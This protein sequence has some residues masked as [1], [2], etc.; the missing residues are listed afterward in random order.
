MSKKKVS[1]W[2]EYEKDESGK[3]RYIGSMYS[4]QEEQR[5][6]TQAMRTLILLGCAL[7]AFLVI[8]GF[9]QADGAMESIF[10][11]VPYLLG[12]VVG[13]RF[14]YFLLRMVLGKNPMK[15]DTYRESVLKIEVSAIF[16]LLFS[17]LTVISES[18]YVIRYGL[19]R[20]PIGVIA[21]LAC[22]TLCGIITYFWIRFFRKLNWIETK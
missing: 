7:F 15:A 20:Y 6:H 9:L 12:L 5:T 19:G 8:A 4:F 10:V 16:V 21:F 18:I 3:Y 11:I 2:D 22:M 13:L 17:I 14:L 1:F